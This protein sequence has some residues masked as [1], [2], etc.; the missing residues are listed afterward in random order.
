MQL[1]FVLL[2]IFLTWRAIL[3]YRRMSLY[4]RL[5]KQELSAEWLETLEKI[6]H[7]RL[8]SKEAK[9]RLRPK[10]LYFAAVKEFICVK[11]EVS[12][13]MKAVISFYASLMVMGYDEPEPFEE[14]DTILIYPHDVVVHGAHESGG[15]FSD[16]EMV[17]EGESAPGT[18]LVTWR[19]ARHE[20]YRHGC[21]N[22]I[23]HELAH[24]L[25]F[26]E[27]YADGTPP[28][29]SDERKHWNNI[30]RRRYEELLD[31]VSKGREWG[32]YRFIGE[33]ASTNEAEFFAVLSERFFQCPVSLEKHFPDLYK[34]LKKFYRI[35]TAALFSA[36]G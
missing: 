2:A 4:K 31:I 12:E 25:D 13:E 21:G 19:E 23:V 1:F 7:Y 28:L 35:D 16:G 9:E 24:L 14:L 32:E 11:C 27:G 3:Y 26:E 30:F 15:V 36:L 22:V 17:L 18:L 10:M 8:L 5:S 33:Y 20:A 34:E 6:P 29:D